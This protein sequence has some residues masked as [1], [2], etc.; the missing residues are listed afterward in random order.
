MRFGT[1]HGRIEFL[2]GTRLD[3][4]RAAVE[5]LGEAGKK[6]N[7]DSVALRLDTNA[8]ELDRVKAT[9]LQSLRMLHR[10]GCHTPVRRA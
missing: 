3:R 1:R 2:P 5:S 8:V 7:R 6:R 10:A 9:R 4:E